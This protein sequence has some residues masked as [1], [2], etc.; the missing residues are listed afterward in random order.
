MKY[1][2]DGDP[3]VWA[4][5]GVNGKRLYSTQKHHKLVMSI[6][7]TNQHD[8]RPLYDGPIIM[9]VTFFMPI[10]SRVQD[11]SLWESTPANMKPDLFNL[12]KLIAE[13][14]QEVLFEDPVIIYKVNAER[15]YARK[16]RT[17]FTI[18]QLKKSEV[19]DQKENN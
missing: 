7:L 1:V 6:H 18:R 4:H 19:Y 17:E 2:L 10:P 5:A 8:D 15:L 3:V 9:D 16:P 14:C 12:I 13:I 11:S